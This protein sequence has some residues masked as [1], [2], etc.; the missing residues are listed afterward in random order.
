MDVKE[1]IIRE[2]YENYSSPPGLGS[3]KDLYRASKEKRRGT[4]LE[5]VRGFLKRSRVYTL[6][7][8]KK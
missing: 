8:L 2:V 1:N 5:D 4:T 6:H 7:R 3:V